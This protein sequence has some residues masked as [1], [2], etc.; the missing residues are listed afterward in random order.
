[1]L[2]YGGDSAGVSPVRHRACTEHPKIVATYQRGPDAFWPFSQCSYL[3]RPRS[4]WPL[5]VCSGW[6]AVAF[7]S[8]VRCLCKST[9][10]EPLFVTSIS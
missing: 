8:P 2:M 7:L 5:P 10:G 6:P 3:V 4:I 9:P 1:M